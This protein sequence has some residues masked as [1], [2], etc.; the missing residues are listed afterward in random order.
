MLLVHHLGL[1]CLFHAQYTA[2]AAADDLAI[3]LWLVLLGG[4]LY[5]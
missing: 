4:P 5:P 3:D 2:L 1:H